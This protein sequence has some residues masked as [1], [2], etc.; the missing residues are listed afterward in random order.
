[1]IMTPH[2]YRFG[3]IMCVVGNSIGRQMLIRKM[4]W[5]VIVY[6]DAY[7]NWKMI[8]LAIPKSSP[9]IS[10]TIF[11][12]VKCFSI[13]KQPAIIIRYRKQKFEIFLPRNSYHIKAK[14]SPPV[15][16]QPQINEDIMPMNVSKQAI[17][18]W[19]SSLWSGRKG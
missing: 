15:A 8:E 10:W 18:S 13:I 11:I 1:M 12:I 6:G 17:L 19:L 3:T 4:N 16:L 9:G 7:L 2:W 5:W 14:M